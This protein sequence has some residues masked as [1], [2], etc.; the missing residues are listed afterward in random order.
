MHLVRS[1]EYVVGYGS[2]ASNKRQEL[3]RELRFELCENTFHAYA[4]YN[5][6]GNYAPIFG[7]SFNTNLGRK[8]TIGKTK[9]GE[10]VLDGIINKNGFRKYNTLLQK[11]LF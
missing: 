5:P 2:P 7:D 1:K 3:L 6:H 9:H 8:L 11:N 4:F 10:H